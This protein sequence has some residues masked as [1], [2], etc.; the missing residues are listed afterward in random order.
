MN[1][2]EIN[3][4]QREKQGLDD[5]E[6]LIHCE[7]ADFTLSVKENILMTLYRGVT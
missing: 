5:M 3:Q 1:E 7:E 2:G 6:P 4:S